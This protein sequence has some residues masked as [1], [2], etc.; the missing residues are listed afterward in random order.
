MADEKVVIRWT[1]ETF[2]GCQTCRFR[3][4]ERG[5]KITCQRTGREINENKVN[6]D[7]NFFDENCPLPILPNLKK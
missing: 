2:N 6:S 1:G 5:R 3:I 4:P 7:Q